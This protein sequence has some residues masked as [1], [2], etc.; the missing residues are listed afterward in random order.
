MGLHG[1]EQGYLYLLLSTH[2]RLGLPSGLFLSG[3]P[4]NILYAFLVSPIR[5]TCPAGK[6]KIDETRMRGGEKTGKARIGNERK[7][8]GYSTNE[9]GKR[10]AGKK[11]EIH[12]KRTK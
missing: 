3:F 4:A 6:K 2:L 11:R 8:N 9:R 1:L 10:G 12:G 7:D 5:V